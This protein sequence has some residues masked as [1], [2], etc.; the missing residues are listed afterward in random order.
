MYEK[1]IS[2]TSKSNEK[3]FVQRMKYHD[4]QMFHN[5]DSLRNAI[6]R[7]Y[8]YKFVIEDKSKVYCV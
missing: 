2:Y 5:I 6:E 7:N 8:E 4:L 3:V 1:Y